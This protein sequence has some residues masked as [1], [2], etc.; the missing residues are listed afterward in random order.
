MSKH[1]QGVI[2]RY[3][4]VRTD[5]S[6]E[7]GKKHDGCRYF[8]LDLEHDPFAANALMAYAEACAKEY[9]QLAEDLESA[10]L[11]IARALGEK[12]EMTFEKGHLWHDGHDWDTVL[13][14][15]IDETD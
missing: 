3:K 10:A 14:Q 9:P 1:E 6:S 2:E 5:G 11:N 4:I 7:P 8:V 15:A 13:D 12:P